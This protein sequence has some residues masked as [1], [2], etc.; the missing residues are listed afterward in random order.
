MRLQTNWK[1]LFAS[2][3]ILRTEST[4][5]HFNLATEEYL[6]ETGLVPIIQLNWLSLPYSF[7]VTV[8]PLSLVGIKIHGKSAVI[9]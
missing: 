2:C 9:S 8:Q 4:N 3:K 6:F 1:R 5:I 7:G